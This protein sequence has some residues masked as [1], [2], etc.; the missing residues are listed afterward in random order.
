MVG[1][2][3]H[4][5]VSLGLRRVKFGSSWAVLDDLFEWWWEKVG[6]ELERLKT[7]A[8]VVSW[9]PMH[10]V[11]KRKRGFD[12]AEILATKLGERLGMRVV[13]LLKRK[14][15][16]VPQFG[17][18]EKERKRNLRGAF[19]IRSGVKKSVLKKKVLLIDDIWTTGSTMREGARVLRKNGVEEVWGVVVA[20]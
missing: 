10:E 6:E 12:Q 8:W 2:R 3:Y 7:E 14:K 20:R 4:G 15:K 1:M 13:A 18:G 11:K 17:L 19:K 9:I 16:T 5:I